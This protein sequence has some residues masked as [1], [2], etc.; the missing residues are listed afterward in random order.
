MTTATLEKRVRTLENEVRTLKTIFQ[1][2]AVILREKKTPMKKLSAGLRQAL[3]E[4][5]EG[6]IAGPFNTVDELM[7]DLES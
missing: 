6:K 4:V 7:A 1:R 5:E 2:G 3:R